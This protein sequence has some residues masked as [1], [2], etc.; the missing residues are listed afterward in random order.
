MAMRPYILFALLLAFALYPF[1]SEAANVV[2]KKVILELQPQAFD[3]G[4]YFSEAANGVLT[5]RGYIFLR[6]REGEYH[7]DLTMQEIGAWLESTTNYGV[8]EYG[9][10]GSSQG[11]TAGESFATWDEANNKRNWLILL[12][13]FTADELAIVDCIPETGPIY[14]AIAFT[15]AYTNIKPSGCSV[16]FISTCHGTAA[17]DFNASCKVAGTGNATNE[18]LIRSFNCLI[19]W[20]E[21]PNYCTINAAAA[22]CQE[23]IPLYWIFTISN[24]DWQLFPFGNPAATVY[25]FS[26]SGGI[27]RWRVTSQY[28]TAG[29]FVEGAS[30]PGGPWETVAHEPPT[31]GDHGVA[32]PSHRYYR[33][34]EVEEDGGALFH[35]RAVDAPPAEP[36]ETA[37]PS[38]ECLHAIIAERKANLRASLQSAARTSAADTMLIVTTDSLAVECAYGIADYWRALGASVSLLTVDGFD[39][40]P[41]VRRGQI[42]AAIID[43][44]AGGVDCLLFVGDANDHVQFDMSKEGSQWWPASWEGIHASYILSGFPPGGQP[45]HDLMPAWYEPDTLPRRQNT[46]YTLPY[47]PYLAK[48]ADVDADGVPDVPW[49]CLPFTSAEQVAGYACKLWSLYPTVSGAADVAFYV[50]DYDYSFVGDGELSRAGADSVEAVL[51]SWVNRHHLYVTDVPDDGERNTAAANFW[52]GSHAGIHVL[53]GSYSSRNKPAHFFDKTIATNPW[54]MGMLSPHMNYYPLV[55]ANSCSGGDWARTEDPYVGSPVLEDFLAAYDRGAFAWIG[56]SAGTWQ[57]GNVLFGEYLMEELYAYPG[58]SMAGSFLTAQRRMLENPDLDGPTKLVARMMCFFGDP[59]ASLNE[60]AA[61]TATEAAKNPPVL[62]L[63]QNAPNPFNPATTIK[64]SIAEP[65][66]VKVT[67]YNAAG[68]LVRTLV[69]EEQKPRAGGFTV[70]WNGTNDAGRRVGSGVYFCRLSMKGASITKKIV[71][72]K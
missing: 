65:G 17:G 30:H 23:T 40:D 48:Y 25:G 47:V 19:S 57:H 70:T 50:C 12:Q 64:Y 35:G 26:V 6:T 45:D 14:Y 31:V 72:L 68:Q 63:E 29:Y 37:S 7:G 3:L 69:H 15:R 11:G 66:R 49:G 55:F 10:H 44:V 36:F 54:H 41:N 52:N 42:H 13:Y 16:A 24:G 1:G 18:Q 9:G 5:E 34:V 32:V 58:R 71:V 8:L 53:M 61:V 39:S 21:D 62:A 60:L 22:K 67:I 46:A 56:P 59:L 4:D 43:S 51:P 38:L 27:A 28:K 2:S 20:L 33:L